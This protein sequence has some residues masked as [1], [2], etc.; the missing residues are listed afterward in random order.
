MELLDRF[1]PDVVMIHHAGT[2]DETRF[3]VTDGDVVRLAGPLALYLRPD[4]APIFADAAG[5][6]LPPYAELRLENQLVAPI[7]TMAWLDRRRAAYELYAV[8][9]KSSRSL[10]FHLYALRA[11]SPFKDAIVQELIASHRDD[12]GAPYLH[13]A[14]ATA[15]HVF[16]ASRAAPSSTTSL[17]EADGALEAGPRSPFLW[18]MPSI[19]ARSPA[20]SETRSYPPSRTS[21]IRAV[22]RAE[23]RASSL[24]HPP[25]GV[26][27]EHHLA[28][29]W[30][31]RGGVV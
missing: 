14:Y 31:P 20:S 8:R 4:Y 24:R 16:L 21:A 9:F 23:T 19:E 2:L 12:R 10:R 1:A 13:S 7:A 6:A 5:R 11:D 3:G 30:V 22:D 25:E 17:S 15:A 26:C 29:L 18:S 28:R 27:R